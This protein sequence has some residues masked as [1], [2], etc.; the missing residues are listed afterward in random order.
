MRLT[1]LILL[2][3]LCAPGRAQDL[4]LAERIASWKPVLRRI[5]PT[6]PS[7]KEF[8]PRL[9]AL[10]ARARH[11]TSPDNI[12]QIRSDFGDW[13]R[14]FMG[15]VGSK[16]SAAEFQPHE[17]ELSASLKEV[18]AVTTENGMRVFYDRNHE[19]LLT[20]VVGS[21]ITEVR[22]RIRPNA[23]AYT[24]HLRNFAT[25]APLTTRALSLSSLAG[26]LDYSGLSN[27]VL[28]RVSRMRNTVA[29]YGTLLDGFTGACYNSVKWM[30]IAGGMMPPEVRFPQEI[31]KAGVG[32]GSPSMMLAKFRRDPNTLARFK[33]RQVDLTNLQR[34]DARSIPEK[35]L[36]VYAPSCAGYSDEHGHIEMVLAPEKSASLRSSAF[37]RAGSGRKSRPTITSDDVLACSDGCNVLSSAYLRTYSRQGCLSAFAPVVDSGISL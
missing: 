26:S 15:H 34:G 13:E 14:D 37:H 33:L 25:P 12:T 28:S 27:A 22:H 4:K 31:G 19:V 10:E 18:A 1:G 29:G 9:D 32:S 17:D 20:M 7:A 6:D 5:A 3:G 23:P 35:T 30:M 2:L 11:E 24:P 36:F 21:G 16:T 8:A